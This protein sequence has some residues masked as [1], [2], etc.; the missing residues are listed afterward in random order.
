MLTGLTLIT[1]THNNKNLTLHY[2]FVPTHQMP[3][4]N[5]ANF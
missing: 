1:D 4:E 3:N 2:K 5:E